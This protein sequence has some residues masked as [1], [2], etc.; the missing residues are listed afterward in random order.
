MDRPKLPTLTAQDLN[1]IAPPVRLLPNGKVE[2]EVTV[3]RLYCSGC[4]TT[5]LDLADPVGGQAARK[6]ALSRGWK[7]FTP[8]TLD[9]R[10]GRYTM[11][12]LLYLIRVRL[13]FL[14]LVQPASEVKPEWAARAIELLEGLG[15]DTPRHRLQDQ[16]ITAE[17]LV[18]Q[19]PD[20]FDRT[21]DLCP[22]C[23]ADGWRQA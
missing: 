18:G 20:A 17:R 9:I 23:H 15:A 22:T 4:G 7:V 6:L 19:N 16:L 5:D 10:K 1:Q 2:R 21:V 13:N 3:A 8:S 11:G 12:Q 14:R